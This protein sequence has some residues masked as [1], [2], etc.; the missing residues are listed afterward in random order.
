VSGLFAARNKVAIVGFA[1]SPAVRRPTETLGATAV[2]TARAAIADAGLAPGQIDGFVSATLMPSSG[3]HEAQDGI[4][5]VSSNWLAKHL[6]VQPEYVVGFQGIGQITGS[7]SLAVNALASGAVDYVLLHRALHNPAGKYN[8]NPMTEIRG[9]QQWTAPQGFFGSVPAIAMAYNEYCQRYGATREAM[10]R[11]VVEA[12]RNGARN[13]WSH[14]RGKP[15][16]VEDYL[17][18]PMVC[19]PIC[20]LDCDIPVEAVSCFV[21]TTLDRAKDLPHKPVAISG[22]AMGYPREH[23]LPLHWTLGEMMDAGK[24][25]ADRLWRNAGVGKDDIDLPQFYDAFSPFVYIWLES[26]GFVPDGEAHR[27]VLDGGIDAAR[28]GSL[29]VLSGGGAIGNG[30]LHGVPQIL[31]CY[32]QLANRKGEGQRAASVALSTYSAPHYGGAFVFT[33]D[34]QAMG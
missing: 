11:L 8:D 17:A 33:N 2:R 9:D 10:A 12:R 32:L 27:F 23:R 19:E 7:L 15:I 34:P 4:S 18:E 22:Y 14:W 24:D 16:T 31:E 26:L 20:R 13:P 25:L 21:L 1:Q 6:G 30:R 28:P 29:A 5:V 3:G